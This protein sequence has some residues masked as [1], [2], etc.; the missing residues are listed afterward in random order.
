VRRCEP[1]FGPAPQIAIG[2][3]IEGAGGD[4]LSVTSISAA[5]GYQFL[6]MAADSCERLAF[7][8]GGGN[9]CDEGHRNLSLNLSKHQPPTAPCRDQ[10][11]LELPG[12][13][14]AR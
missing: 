11:L 8:V 7:Y 3:A 14:G 10:P 4:A 12:S 1:I 2:A 5:G 13:Y 9:A 6:R